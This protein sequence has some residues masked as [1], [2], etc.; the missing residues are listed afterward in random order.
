MEWLIIAFILIYITSFVMI[1][2]IKWENNENINKENSYLYQQEKE[3]KYYE[4]EDFYNLHI[5]KVLTNSELFLYNLLKNYFKET[6]VNIFTKIRLADLVKS[7]YWISWWE[8]MKTFNKINR[9]HIDFIITDYSGKILVLI[10]LDDKTHQLQ[11]RKNS[12]EMKNELFEILWVPLI[13]YRL[14]NY[15]DLKLLNQYI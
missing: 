15:Y 11:E 10:E 2:L 9:K 3:I 4:N 13:R 1:T 6:N 8:R 7:K 5:N 12:D 14:W